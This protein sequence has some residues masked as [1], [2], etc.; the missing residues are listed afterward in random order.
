MSAGLFHSLLSMAPSG[1]LYVSLS[2]SGSGSGL[3]PANS[4][5]LADFLNYT[6]TDDL[7]VLFKMDDVF[8]S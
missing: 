4:M 3:S 2:G 6:V 8:L 1:S 5:S 7:T